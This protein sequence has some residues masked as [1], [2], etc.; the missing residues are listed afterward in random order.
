MKAVIPLISTVLVLGTLHGQKDRSIFIRLS[1]TADACQAHFSRQAIQD[2]G[3]PQSA[4]GM[5]F[6][7][8]SPENGEEWKLEA[9]ETG[10]VRIPPIEGVWQIFS[11]EKKRHYGSVAEK[12][13]ACTRWKQEPNFSFTLSPPFPDTLIITLHRTC[14][15][16]RVPFPIAK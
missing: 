13:S 1:W 16:C 5:T 6:Y 11:Y 10:C 14:P 7:L 15:P 2:L 4:A 9:D 12:D 8:R 3:T